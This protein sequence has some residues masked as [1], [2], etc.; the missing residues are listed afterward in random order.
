MAI[1]ICP[2]IMDQF[3]PL[4]KLGMVPGNLLPY[5]ESRVARQSACAEGIGTD[6][7]QYETNTYDRP[8]WTIIQPRLCGHHEPRV[9]DDWQN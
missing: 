3:E 5:Y 6:A 4:V 1:V 2:K 9:Y 7:A 8:E